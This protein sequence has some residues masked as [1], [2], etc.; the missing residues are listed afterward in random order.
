LARTKPDMVVSLIPNF[1]RPMYA[2]WPPPG[3]PRRT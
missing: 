2:R 1:N 3:P